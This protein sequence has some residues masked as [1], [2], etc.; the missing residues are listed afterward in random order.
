MSL[1]FADLGFIDL[2]Q[3]Y[4]LKLD[5]PLVHDPGACATLSEEELRANLAV[6]AARNG[7]IELGGSREEMEKRLRK[8]LERRQKD[9]VVQEF[10]LEGFA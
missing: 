7:S 3:E 5:E 9:M 2:H 8:L 10:M 4:A 6:H 1:A